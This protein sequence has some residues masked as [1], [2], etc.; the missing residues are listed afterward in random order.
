M[1]LVFKGVMS[2]DMGNHKRI[3]TSLEG[4]LERLTAAQPSGD[5]GA[6]DPSCDLETAYDFGNEE[7]RIEIVEAIVHAADLSG[8][9]L[10]QAVA[11]EFGRRVLKE[12][13]SQSLQEKRDNLPVTAFMT[14]LDDVLV[15]AKVQLGFLNYVVEPLWNS[16]SCILPQIKSRHEAVLERIAEINFDDLE[17][18]PGQ[19]GELYQN[20]DFGSDESGD[21][22]E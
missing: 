17:R 10:P 5:A 7:D 9:A 22:V 6:T 2:T 16:L 18:W 3:V 13:H 1:W 19:C 11:Y 20:A 8:Q 12:F 21:S 4:R 14:N 15:Q